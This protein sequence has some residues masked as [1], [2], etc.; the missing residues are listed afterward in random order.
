MCDGRPVQRGKMMHIISTTHGYVITDG[1]SFVQTF[2]V[3]TYESRQ[4]CLYAAI[5]V[6]IHH[7]TLWCNRN[8][9]IDRG[10]IVRKA[11]AIRANSSIERAQQ[12]IRKG[13]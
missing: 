9:R 11:G 7:E 10:R 8:N 13:Q 1:M 2:L 4:A 5:T 12:L 3:N 6:A